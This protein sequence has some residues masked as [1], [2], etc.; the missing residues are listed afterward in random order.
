[1]ALTCRFSKAAVWVSREAVS[2]PAYYG[3]WRVK[4]K[5]E[6]TLLASQTLL[7]MDGPSSETPD[8]S[9]TGWKVSTGSLSQESNLGDL[10]DESCAASQACGAFPCLR[11]RVVLK[12]FIP[13]RGRNPASCS[14]LTRA[15]FGAKP[16]L[17][18]G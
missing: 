18:R 15:A 10:K 7:G 17:G 5:K 6:P 8:F 4:A 16:W 1:M 13:L 2:G 9:V 3:M 12:S 14:H 11:Q